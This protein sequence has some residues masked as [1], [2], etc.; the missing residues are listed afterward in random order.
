MDT[1]E[2]SK[3][4]LFDDQQELFGITQ[5]AFRLSSKT[6][7]K[8]N[9][10]DYWDISENA[11]K[12]LTF[13]NILNQE[14]QGLEVESEKW[15]SSNAVN[16][17]SDIFLQIDTTN[18]EK[19][20]YTG[21]HKKMIIELKS[22]RLKHSFGYDITYTEKKKTVE[23]LLAEYEQNPLDLLRKYKTQMFKQNKGSH[24]AKDQDKEDKD[25]KLIKS[26]W[27][28]IGLPEKV[29]GTVNLTP[30]MSLLASKQETALLQLSWYMNA[31]HDRPADKPAIKKNEKNEK[32]LSA[33]FG[34]LLLI[35]GS[36]ILAFGPCMYLIH[37]QKSHGSNMYF[38]NLFCTTPLNHNPKIISSNTGNQE[39][40]EGY[41]SYDSDLDTIDLIPDT[42]YENQGSSSDS[43]YNYPDF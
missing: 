7:Y 42:Y 38:V 43:E 8:L 2:N 18:P 5:L 41:N 14:K 1:F 21:I 19:D 32:N 39:E 24:T 4:G 17:N 20:D 13:S 9:F 31:E 22:L 30:N 23:K 29:P 40:V 15:I 37:L 11:L 36:L 35:E 10:K 34:N 27:D 6:L 28:F 16:G 33:D 25:E 26:I 12:M 3:K